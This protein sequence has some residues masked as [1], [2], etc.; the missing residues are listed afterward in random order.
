MVAAPGTDWLVDFKE[1]ES[2]ADS[3]NCADTK[4]EPRVVR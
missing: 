3:A 4:S 1:V 2:I